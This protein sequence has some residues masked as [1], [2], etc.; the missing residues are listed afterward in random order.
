VTVPRSA[1]VVDRL[2]L[3][4]AVVAQLLV[5]YLPRVDAPGAGAPGLDKLT[6]AAVFAAVAWTGRRAGVDPRLLLVLL[7]VQ[8]VASEAVQGALLPERSGDPFDVAA[9]L[10][11][12]AVGLLLPL[13]RRVPEPDPAA[14]GPAVAR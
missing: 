4:A 11:G 3:A 13:G 1:H 8:A 5:L 7:V 6:H 12:T 10:A 14:S 9:D 2:L